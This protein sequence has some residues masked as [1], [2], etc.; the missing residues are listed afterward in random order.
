MLALPAPSGRVFYVDAYGDV[1]IPT[2]FKAPGFDLVAP[3]GSRPS[4]PESWPYSG[5]TGYAPPPP[6]APPPPP[7]GTA[8]TAYYKGGT[9][10]YGDNG[11]GGDGGG[12]VPPGVV[13]GGTGGGGEPSHADLLGAYFYGR[14]IG[15]MALKT[16]TGP[17]DAA[18]SVAQKLQ[19]M[20]SAGMTPDQA[21]A[22]Y[23]QASALRSQ[24]QYATLTLDELLSMNTSAFVVSRSAD[25]AN[26]LMP[27]L[28]NATTILKGRG[29]MDAAASLLQLIRSGDL[30]GAL[31]SLNP[32]GS[33]NDQPMVNFITTAVKA[34][35]VMPPGET[36]D[37]TQVLRLYQ[38]L[39]PAARALSPEGQTA[40]L[41][42]AMSMG[43]LKA[44]TGIS[45]DFKELVG[46]KMSMGVED[47]MAQAGLINTKG[48]VRHGQYVTLASGAL[49]DQELFDSDPVAW[50]AKDFAPKFGGLDNKDQTTLL[51]GMYAAFNTAQGSRA[52][53]DS[54]YNFN[55]IMRIVQ[56]AENQ[57]ALS[58]L[59]GGFNTT[60]I[61]S[62]TAA[63][64]ATN[65]IL[66]TVGD[67]IMNPLQ[68][69]L[70]GYTKAINSVNR[71]AQK[72]PLET[73]VTIAGGV[74]AAFYGLLK[75]WG[76]T[77]FP[78]SDSARGAATWTESTALAGWKKLND[79]IKFVERL[80]GGSK[81]A[82]F[83]GTETASKALG[84]ASLAVAI[85]AAL[86]EMQS[87]DFKRGLDA[88]AGG[89]A[90]V[91]PVS[92][93]PL[94]QAIERQTEKLVRAITGSAAPSTMPTGPAQP[95]ASAQMPNPGRA[96]RP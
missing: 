28:A 57:P 58:A 74:G 77:K 63:G 65:A 78:F 17:F 1:M 47:V 36:V 45:Q 27:T 20:E 15:G 59:A 41:A 14:L 73:D 8:L 76:Q 4:G 82:D 92:D 60:P 89:D 24:A 19:I 30:V 33:V 96:L 94:V 22:A 26:G 84:P 51:H 72:H 32:D 37:A 93:A 81:D 69:F 2:K 21:Q 18:A 40:V 86:H 91:V 85:A 87:K 38:N 68:S 50:F 62:R 12:F 75:L 67:S 55:M 42:L 11:D 44:G 3:P 31:N 13:P 25:V 10:T 61:G 79:S 43:Q 53:A 6:A 34:M 35:S 49:K 5:D 70:T 7:P 23:A 56:A 29:E 16:V 9:W 64:S 46:G 66:V 88:L 90:A 39:G 80:A 95:P 54:A 71:A 52:A 83:I 48:A